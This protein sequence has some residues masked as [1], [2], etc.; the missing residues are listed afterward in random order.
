[1]IMPHN[2]SVEYDMEETRCCLTQFAHGNDSICR[3]QIK[4]THTKRGIL[5]NIS[6]EVDFASDLRHLS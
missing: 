5:L 1:M 2:R 4:V 6:C 3:E